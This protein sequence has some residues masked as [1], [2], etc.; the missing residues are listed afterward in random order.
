MRLLN[1][2]PALRD[3]VDQALDRLIADGTIANAFA[4]Y[5][6]SYTPPFKR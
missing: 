3:A 2:D 4:K 6:V 5:G 1:A